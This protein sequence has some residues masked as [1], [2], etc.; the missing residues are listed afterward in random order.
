MGRR[1]VFLSTMRKKVKQ[2]QK[3]YMLS[4]WVKTVVV[5]TVTTVLSFLFE[6]LGIRQSNIVTV[7]ILG[8]LVTAAI[9][10]SRIYSFDALGVQCA[11]L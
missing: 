10:A 9:T 3:Y 4:D 6:E 7:Y 11:D 2:E 5:A 8:V 1:E